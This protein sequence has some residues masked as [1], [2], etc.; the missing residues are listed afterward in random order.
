[1]ILKWIFGEIGWVGLEWI[2]MAQDRDQWKASVNIIMNT[3]ISRNF[4]NT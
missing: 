2:V 1:M 4:A 3:E